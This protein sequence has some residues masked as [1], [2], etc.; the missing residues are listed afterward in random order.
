[1]KKVPYKSQVYDKN[2]HQYWDSTI[3]INVYR[4][5][6]KENDCYY[7]T[8]NGHYCTKYN[9]PCKQYNC[10]DK[11]IVYFDE[12]THKRVELK[13]DTVNTKNNTNK[14]KENKLNHKTNAKSKKSYVG[15]V[16]MIPTEDSLNYI[17][18]II[19]SCDKDNIYYQ[20]QGVE[21]CISKNAKYKIL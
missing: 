18:G 13:F 16:I 1:M 15:R 17:T 12:E 9:K 21:K 8:Q 14:L 11:K 6:K 10:K 5:T 7:S 4:E 3:L 19:C 2:H 20:Y